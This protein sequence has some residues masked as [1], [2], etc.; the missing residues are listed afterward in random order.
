MEALRPAL[1][2]RKPT[3]LDVEDWAVIAVDDQP[4]IPLTREGMIERARFVKA[5]LA[6]MEGNP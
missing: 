1:A 4:R 3:Y 5:G 6:A 2:D